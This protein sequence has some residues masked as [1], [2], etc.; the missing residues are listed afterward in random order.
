MYYVRCL[1]PLHS[2]V[3]ANNTALL[4]SRGPIPSRVSLEVL[5]NLLCG[6]GSFDPSRVKVNLGRQR[7]TKF[8]QHFTEIESSFPRKFSVR[9]PRIGTEIFRDTVS[10]EPAA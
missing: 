6:A 5:G 1:G 7:L 4:G 3:P 9:L 8:S 2:R 10:L